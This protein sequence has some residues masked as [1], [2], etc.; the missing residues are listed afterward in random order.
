MLTSC[1]SSDISKWPDTEI[2]GI[3]YKFL[4]FTHIQRYVEQHAYYIT[5]KDFHIEFL[6]N[7]DYLH[8]FSHLLILKYISIDF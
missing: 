6:V 7:K 3:H 1:V 5:R 2:L 8:P 4:L